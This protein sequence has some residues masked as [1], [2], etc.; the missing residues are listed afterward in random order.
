MELALIGGLLLAIAGGGYAL[1]RWGG[2][3]GN[4]EAKHAKS[5][6]KTAQMEHKAV[7]ESAREAQN[8]R[9][10]VDAMPPGAAADE[11]RDEYSRD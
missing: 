8:I 7:I 11:L 2:A 10:E 6:V 5:A 4:S 3:T 9:H 1:Y